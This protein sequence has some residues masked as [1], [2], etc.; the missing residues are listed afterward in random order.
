M[1]NI[2][3]RQLLLI[4]NQLDSLCIEIW[5]NQTKEYLD[6]DAMLS[7]ARKARLEELRYALEDECI[8]YGEL[9]ELQEL[10]PYIEPGDVQLLEA[11]GVSE[12]PEDEETPP[13]CVSKQL[14]EITARAV[15]EGDGVSLAA[16]VS[17]VLHGISENYNVYIKE[18]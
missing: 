17:Q 16:K 10:I 15:V 13:A 3:T 18:L 2:E 7:E 9:A 14:T 1:R 12:F 5:D 11:A 6:I 4:L 8:S